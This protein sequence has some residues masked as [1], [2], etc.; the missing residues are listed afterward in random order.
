MPHAHPI[1]QI[2]PPDSRAPLAPFTALTK[3]E[4]AAAR[5]RRGESPF[6]SGCPVRPFPTPVACAP[7]LPSCP[8]WATA[9]APLS[10]CPRHPVFCPCLGTYTLPHTLA[11]PPQIPGCS[12]AR[13]PLLVLAFRAPHRVTR[14]THL[15]Q[16]PGASRSSHAKAAPAAPP[17]GL[18]ASGPLHV[19]I[20]LPGMPF[21]AWGER[22][23][24]SIHMKRDHYGPH[25]P[26]C[27]LQPRLPS[28]EYQDPVSPSQSTMSLCTRDPRWHYSQ[29]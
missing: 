27:S 21:S 22:S 8:T 2:L 13:S 5:A 1:I 17:A 9:A 3:P 7:G 19:W 12:R 20:L 11:G 10:P 24:F 25:L 6:P 15:L 14:P 18:L 28:T 26:R 4:W 23:S 16:P 29:Q